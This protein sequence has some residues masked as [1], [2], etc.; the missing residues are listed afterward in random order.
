MPDS[1]FIKHKASRT[2]DK[3]SLRGQRVT[4]STPFVVVEYMAQAIVKA[5]G[6]PKPRVIQVIKLSTIPDDFNT[7]GLAHTVPKLDCLIAKE[8][9]AREAWC[10]QVSDDILQGTSHYVNPDQI[11]AY[12]LAAQLQHNLDIKQTGLVPL[13]K[14]ITFYRPN[15]RGNRVQ[16]VN[17]KDL[18][19]CQQ[20]LGMTESD[21]SI[22]GYLLLTPDSKEWN[23]F[24]RVVSQYTYSVFSCDVD[25]SVVELLTRKLKVKSTGEILKAAFNVREKYITSVN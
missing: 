19:H 8:P 6:L 4:A 7:K 25:T 5:H 13:D 17:G 3:H 23:R 22:Q 24:S 18:K 2:S 10:K 15:L 14:T 20:L 11:Y 21:W 9:D 12:V 16:F 1:K